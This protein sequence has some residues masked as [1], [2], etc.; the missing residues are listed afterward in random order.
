MSTGLR[1]I[2]ERLRPRE[3]PQTSNDRNTVM[4]DARSKSTFSIL[5]QTFLRLD[6]DYMLIGYDEPYLFP[7]WQNATRPTFSNPDEASLHLET[8][9]AKIFDVYELVAQH[10][11]QDLSNR[12][13]ELMDSL[14]ED[15]QICFLR[16]SL[17]SVELD[18][19]L[20]DVEE[21]CKESLH[22]WTKAFRM[23]PETQA[24]MLSHISTQ[25]FFFCVYNWIETWHD[26]DAC[27]VDRFEPQFAYFTDLCERYLQLHAAKTPS[28]NVFGGSDGA[29]T[30]RFHTP[31]AFSLG[32]GVVTCLAAIV[33]SCRT[34]LIRRR[35]IA[36]LQ[37][38]NLRGIFDTN[39]LATYLEAIVD[40]EERA[41]QLHNPDLDVSSGLKACDIPEEARLLEVM[42]SPARHRGRFD[43]YKTDRVNA[44]F[45][46]NGQ[47]LEFGRLSARVSR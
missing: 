37:K 14:D 41:A 17:R 4:I 5:V 34:S 10:T 8:I 1:I 40:H 25:I 3:E 23:V 18:R 24:N 22:A 26:V 15:Q 45:V 33:E 7:I 13:P 32:S 19:S 12:Q 2:H 47:K 39:Y 9:T 11:L 16:A 29:G 36:L 21:E 44:V 46:T 20:K 38:I 43:F 30:G 31:P 42:M 6:S 35:C 27:L 28:Y